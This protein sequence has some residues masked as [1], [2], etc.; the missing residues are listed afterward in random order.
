[1]FQ[2]VF[3]LVNTAINANIATLTVTLIGVLKPF[4]FACVLLY[5]V[6]S[7]YRALFD[8]QNLM[9]MESVNF[10]IK[11]FFLGTIALTSTYYI[12]KLVPI[13]LNSGDLV[14][15]ELVGGAPANTVL[16][17]MF[18]DTIVR[19]Q[20]MWNRTSLE[21][22]VPVSWKV[23]FQKLA[24]VTMI[25]IGAMPFIAIAFVYLLVAKIMMS[26]LLILGPL[27][28]MMAFFPSTRS[29]FQAWTGQIF[30]Y[31]L[32]TIVYPIAF[33]LFKIVLDEVF[34]SQTPSFVMSGL[35]LVMFIA[36]ILVALQIPTFCS[37]LSGGIGINGLVGGLGNL[38]SIARSGGAA[39]KGVG[40]TGTKGAGLLNKVSIGTGKNKIAAG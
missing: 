28:I 8:P 10:F 16:Q 3:N 1:M 21:I 24:A 15:A 30:N 13:L 27:F 20:E 29:F 33:N 5:A 31:A 34:F 2:E 39:M 7:A 22:S 11:L 32:L 38:G 37:S 19:V 6:Y 40:A 14:A 9:I 35:A 36:M 23:F 4:L 18:T 25:L 17:Q 26:F 12:D